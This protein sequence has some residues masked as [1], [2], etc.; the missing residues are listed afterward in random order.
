[1]LANG[2]KLAITWGSA[3]LFTLLHA[4]DC[5]TA[6]VATG[7]ASN[8]TLGF[9]FRSGSGFALTMALQLSILSKSLSFSSRHFTSRLSATRIPSIQIRM[10]TPIFQVSDVID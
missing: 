4:F 8:L 6:W 1:M 5:T 3:S 7:F 10:Q 9:G 2:L